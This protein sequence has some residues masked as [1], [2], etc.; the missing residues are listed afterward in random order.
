MK[1]KWTG[2]RL[3]TFIYNRDAIDHLH[4]YALVSN[5]IESKII[6]DIASGEGYGSHLMCEKASFVYGVD[7]DELTISKAKL[8]YQ[9]KNLEFLVGNTSAIPLEN[10][11]VDVVISFETIE[12]HDE[13]EQMMVEI[14]RVLKP[15]GIVVI[16]TPDKKYYSDLRNF[17]NQFHVKELYKNEFVNLL[18]TYFK[19]IQ[20]FN[21]RYCNGNS[22]IYEDI[23]DHQLKFYSGNYSQININEPHPLY[24]IAIM[25]DSSLKLQYGSFFDGNEILKE[26]IDR[27]NAIVYKSNTYK[28][29]H[30]LLRP[31]KFLKKCYKNVIHNNPIL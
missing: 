16:S 5:F 4:R 20:L 8:K 27:E 12:H 30:F 1:K 10:Q 29:G 25:S 13:H 6:L 15:N 26:Q 22:I 23:S 21:Q 9:K 11:S 24:L 2:E 14:K 18:S 31:L 7:I 19:N 3:E 28:L 17:H